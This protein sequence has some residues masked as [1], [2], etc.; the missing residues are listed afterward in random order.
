MNTHNIKQN[1]WS[2][3]NKKYSLNKTLR[4]ELQPVGHTTDFLKE[5]K[6]FEKDKTIDDA[7]NQAKFYFDK[8]HQKFINE[9]LSYE[10]IKELNL[11]E[12]TNKF[13]AIK[14]EIQDLKSQ[15]KRKEAYQKEKEI[16]KLRESYYKKIK[17]FLDKKADEER[18]K[19]QKKGINFNKS[20]LKQK[21]TDFLT[22]AGVLKILKYEFPKEKEE[23]FKKNDWP[24][25]YVEDKAN[26][27]QKVY[28]FDEFDK[29]TTYLT[30]FQ[31]TRK[32]LYKDDGTSTA[33]ATRVISNFEKFLNN[34]KIFDEKYENWKEIGLDQAQIKIFDIDY[35]YNCFIQKGIDEYNKII[36]EI[37]KKSK[38]YRDK[39]KIDKNQL[40]LFKILEKQILGEVKKERELIVATNTETGE[41]VFIKRFKELIE[42]NKQRIPKAEVLMKDLF[43][44]KF[45]ENY[46]GI[47]LRKQAINTIVNRWFKIPKEFLSVLP[48]VLKSKKKEDKENPKIKPFVSL[49]DIKNGLVDLEEKKDELGNIFK[50]KY[51]KTENNSE[52]PLIENS[53]EGYWVQF[54][55]VWRYE[56]ENLFKD[57]FDGYT[58]KLENQSEELNTFSR[59]KEEIKIVKNYCD[60]VLKIYQ[61]MKYFALEAKNEKDIPSDYSTEF[62]NFFDEYYKEF[63]LVRYYNAI[64]NFVTKKPSDENKIKLNFESGV[65]MTGFDKNK[66]KEKLGIILR[67]E[68]KYFVGIINKKYNKIFDDKKYPELKGE[69]NDK[70][71]KMELKL[72]PDPTKMVPKIAF[73]DKNAKLLGLTDEIKKIKEEYEKFQQDKKDKNAVFDKEKL[74]KLIAYYQSCLEKSGYKEEFGFNW[75]KP[76]E[77]KNLSE[78]NKDIEKNNYKIKFV[79]VNDDY[80]S[81]KVKN[82]QLYLFEILNKDFV[83]P[84]KKRNI[85]TLYFLNLFSEE[86]I[87]NPIFRLGANAEVFYRK[88]TEKPYEEERGVHRKKK[89]IKYKRYTEDKILFHF[90]IE[91]NYGKQKVPNE[92]NRKKAFAAK[93]NK[94]LNKF[95]S[96]KI[97]QINIIGIDRGEKNLLYYTVIN[98]KGEILEHSSLNEINGVNYFEKLIEKEKE[99]QLN[100][101]SWEPVVK[102]KDLKKGYLSYVV[103]KVTDLVEKWNAII[104]L[105]D[106]NMRFKQV[107]GGIERTIYQQFEK[108]LIDKLGYLVFKDERDPKSPGGI[109]NGYQLVAPFTTFRD[110]GKQTGIIFYTNAEYTSKTDPLTGY[111]KNI[112]ISNSASQ[113]KIIDLINKLKALGWNEKEQ[114]YFFTYNQKDFDTPF[115]KEWTL[116]SKAPRIKKEKDNKTGYWDYKPL[117]LNKEFEDLFNKYGIDCKSNNILE[118]LKEIIKNDSQKLTKKFNFDGKERNFYERF[119]FLF[120]VLLE[121][122]NTM[123]LYLEI[124]KQSNKLVKID[125]GVDFFASPVKP[126]FSTLGVNYIVKENG[127]NK[128][129]KTEAKRFAEQNLSKFENLFKN[130]LSDG[131]DS[132]GVGAYNIARKGIIILEKIKQNPE[133]PDLFISKEDWDKFVLSKTF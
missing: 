38:E 53:Q 103:R 55:K 21:G 123:S 43:D 4:F 62:Y 37:N 50:N 118:E 27:G 78:F 81:E 121:I 131:F 86:N 98:Q 92:L 128:L 54:L 12:F 40:P 91:I 60:A 93:F 16:I 14:K 52:A 113:K 127:G 112:Y 111:R 97:D 20:D 80:I 8:L 33:V 36:G 84:N 57:E 15:Q 22:K 74:T 23:E 1:I 99:R 120:N 19:Y 95:L 47:Y 7:Y 24:S 65:L 34:Q 61:M 107:R 79:K 105:E 133:N 73:A 71:E 102:I 82:G 2:E 90:P 66:E 114:S 48:Q 18:R 119:I 109:L 45:E 85:H 51:Y 25:L 132:D 72:F 29:F 41:Q 125:Y 58:E 42:E 28:I 106:L 63:E 35:Y 122:R 9:A 13:L 10:N 3:F 68:N 94:E 129:V 64:R 77:Y 69:S 67:K 89:V 59:K 32:N 130:C 76:E 117:N 5:N 44:G 11:E 46:D 87:N 26:S 108:Q 30:K 110:L 96:K 75:K 126:F 39:N 115:D 83:W 6:I 70:Y 31:E 17:T 104:V 56:F 116:Y 49:L 101:Q 100:R 88:A 124:D